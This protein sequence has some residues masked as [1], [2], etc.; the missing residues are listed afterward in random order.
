MGWFNLAL[1]QVNHFIL[2][3]FPQRSQIK[4]D[5]ELPHLVFNVISAGLS[6]IFSRKNANFLNGLKFI[7]EY[8]SRFL[9]CSKLHGR[10]DH[11]KL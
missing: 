8:K 11:F 4:H 9:D 1:T 7:K 3:F 10:I 5:G 6:Q 2:F